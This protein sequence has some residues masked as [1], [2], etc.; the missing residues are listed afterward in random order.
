MTGPNGLWLRAKTWTRVHRS[1]AYRPWP[2]GSW[3]NGTALGTVRRTS[4][5]LLHACVPFICEH[6]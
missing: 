5:S 4:M 1:L 3:M 6:P 2:R